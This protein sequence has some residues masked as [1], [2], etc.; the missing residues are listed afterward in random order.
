[1]ISDQVFDQPKV[2][3][4]RKKFNQVPA[5]FYLAAVLRKVASETAVCWLTNQ[6]RELS[7]NSCFLAFLAA[8]TSCKVAGCQVVDPKDQTFRPA[9]LTTCSNLAP[10]ARQ[11]P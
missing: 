4:T 11:L 3:S 5:T 2:A 9:E 10:Y 6:T 7:T 1:M 8:G